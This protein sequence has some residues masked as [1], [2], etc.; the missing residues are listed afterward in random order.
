M[1]SK[2]GDTISTAGDTMMSVGGYHEY[3]GGFPYKFSCFPMTFPHIYHI[4]S[5][6]NIP[7]CTEHPPLYCTPPGV[8]HRHYAGCSLCAQGLSKTSVKRPNDK[9]EC[10]R[11]FG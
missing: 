8:L 9:V 5:V 3:S 11:E 1:F 7:C 6:L 4:P 2:L 10:E